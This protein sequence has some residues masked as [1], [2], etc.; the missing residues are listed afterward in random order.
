MK[1]KLMKI[2][3]IASAV[4]FLS[5]GISM[6]HDWKGGHHKP[7]GHSYGDYKKWHAPHNGWHKKNFKRNH[8]KY[9]DRYHHKTRHE[10]PHH[11]VGHYPSHGGVFFGFSVA[12][13]NFAFS[14][15]VKGR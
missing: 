2:L 5:A 15:G 13:P 11:N 1:S 10:Y 3:I 14:V 8:Y 9:R 12:D 6:A 4:F 7:G